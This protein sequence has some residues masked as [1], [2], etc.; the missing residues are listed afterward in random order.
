MGKPSKRYKGDAQKKTNGGNKK[1][2]QGNWE[3]MQQTL[4]LSPYYLSNVQREKRWKH[5]CEI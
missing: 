1:K 2:K 3:Q 4:S 5:K